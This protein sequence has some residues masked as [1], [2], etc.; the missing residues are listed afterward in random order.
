MFFCE[1]FLY[2]L[3]CITMPPSFIIVAKITETLKLSSVVKPF[4][5]KQTSDIDDNV[6]KIN[7]SIA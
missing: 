1:M 7:C 3:S 5:I 6:F 2:T 4:P